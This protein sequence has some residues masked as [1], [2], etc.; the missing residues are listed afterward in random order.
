MAV[1]SAA[2]AIVGTAAVP[3]VKAPA[4][5]NS[6]RLIVTV[7]SPPGLQTIRHDW[8]QRQENE[9]TRFQCQNQRLERFT[10]DAGSGRGVA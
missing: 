6:L 1:R 9:G 7:P 2:M 8:E 5:M 4:R 3:I 10:L